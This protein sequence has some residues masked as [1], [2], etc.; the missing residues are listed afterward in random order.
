MKSLISNDE[1]K[2]IDLICG[3]YKIRKYSINPDGSIDVA[4]GV[5][6]YRKVLNELPLTFKNVSGSFNCSYNNLTSLEG[7]PVTVGGNFFCMSNKLTTLEG[8]PSTVVGGFYWN[9]NKLVSTF[10]GDTDIETEVGF[11]ISERELSS[12]VLPMHIIDNY[13]HIKLILKYQRHFFIWNDDLTL[14]E[15]NFQ[16]LLDEIKDGL[17]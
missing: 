6:L 5:D 14:N 17:L 13:V 1:K 4:G 9:K 12:S 7:S 10:S 3:H 11:F 16:V 8:S 2:R 15:D